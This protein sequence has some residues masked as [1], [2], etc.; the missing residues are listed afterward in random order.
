MYVYIYICFCTHIYVYIYMYIYVRSCASW[1]CSASGSFLGCLRSLVLPELGLFFRVLCFQ[2]AQKP[3]RKAACYAV[4]P[5][6]MLQAC[7]RRMMLQASIPGSSDF[8]T[9]KVFDCRFCTICTHGCF[10]DFSEA[11]TFQWLACTWL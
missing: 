4:V 2:L 9:L 3:T 7:F 10:N 11:W 5:L 1:L 6:G 8:S